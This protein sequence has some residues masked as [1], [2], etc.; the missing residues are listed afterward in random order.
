[1]P[2]HKFQFK[3]TVHEEHIEPI[4]AKPA[5]PTKQVKAAPMTQQVTKITKVQTA[6]ISKKL[7]GSMSIEEI[8]ID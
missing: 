3:E 4:V 5:K 7:Q 6:P 2:V 8:D 1:M